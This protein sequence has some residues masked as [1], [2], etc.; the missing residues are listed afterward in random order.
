MAILRQSANSNFNGADPATATLSSAPVEGNLLIA[1][2]SERSGGSA[3]NHALTG[4][5]GWTHEISQTIEQGNGSYRRTHSMF[6]KEAGASEPS[7]VT[8]DDGTSNGKWLSV[9]EFELETGE[10]QWSFLASVSNNNGTT[11][12]ATTISTGSTAS[13]SGD[14]FI[15]ASCVVKRGASGVSPTISWDS[16][17]SSDGS[18][19]SGLNYDMDHGVGS[20]AADTATGAKS[21]TATLSNSVNNSGLSAA[22]IVF[23][24][25]GSGATTHEG[26]GTLDADVGVT[27]VNV[28]DFGPSA[29]IE[30]S[31]DLSG[32]A[33]LTSSQGGALDSGLSV[34]GSTTADSNQNGTLNSSASI[35]GSQDSA[36]EVA[37]SIAASM[38]VSGAAIFTT[39]QSAALALISGVTSQAVIITD[40]SGA[41]AVSLSVSGDGEVGNIEASG[42]LALTADL[43][44]QVV[45]Q[46]EAG[47]ALGVNPDVTASAIA[48][49]IE[50]GTLDLTPG[51]TAI[52]GVEIDG[53]GTID[54]SA[55]MLG[56]GSIEVVVTVNSYKTYTVQAAPKTYVITYK[57]KKFTVQ[58]KQK[59]FTVH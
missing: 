57:P 13:Q 53:A 17:L 20:D 36:L 41:L 1:V 52:G 38:G 32:L 3:S 18:Y 5:T 50:S 51:A 9:W 55:S 34:S 48:T 29:S 30:A 28:A 23:D 59:K 19:S 8:L 2:C 6:Y 26:A 54:Y 44:G 7:S 37:A 22:L 49:L 27:G 39:E 12:S 42:S 58:A 11:G 43:T 10:D 47:S 24:T 21:S 14:M 40:Q 4:I 45:A 46:F 16:G 25:I 31:S 35:S 56:D 15:V 33:A